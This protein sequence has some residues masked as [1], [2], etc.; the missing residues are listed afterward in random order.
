MTKEEVRSVSL[1]KLRLRE[2]DIFYDVGAG[3]GSVSVEAALRLSRHRICPGTDAEAIS[4]LH[5]N[6]EK[7]AVPNLHII[8]GHAPDT[9]ASLPSPDRAFLGGTGGHTRAV[10][11]A[12]RE[13]NPSVRVV[14]N[15]ITLE[16]L[17]ETLQA[18]QE[19]DF[20]EVDIVQLQVSKAK[21]AG[22]II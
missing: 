12:L 17:T 11:A 3:T 7:W 15:V 18:F 16:S 4:L 13:K 2:T 20:R 10:L 22:R 1:S 6:K 8:P 19:L 9:F 21:K 14:A 5:A